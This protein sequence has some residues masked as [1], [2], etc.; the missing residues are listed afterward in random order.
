MHRKGR[1][2]HLTIPSTGFKTHSA[3]HRAGSLF[4]VA[5]VTLA[6]FPGPF[7]ALDTGVDGSYRYGLNRL[8]AEGA[9]HG[10]D[11]VFNYGPLGYL[12][13][14]LD[15]GTNLMEAL[16]FQL[17][18]LALFAWALFLMARQQDG[19]WMLAGFA[20]AYLL[21]L[22]MGF[23]FDYQLLLLIAMLLILLHRHPRN[24]ALAAAA[25]ALAGLTVFMKFS[26]GIAAMGMLLASIALLVAGPR[27]R[28]KR[29]VAAG[30]GTAGAVLLAVGWM[31]FGEL[32]HLGRWIRLSLEIVR[33]YSGAM[34]LSGSPTAL[35]LAQAILLV[36]V[37]LLAWAARGRSELLPVLLVLLVPL[38]LAYKHGFVRQATHAALFFR[39]ALPMVALLPVFAGTGRNRRAALAGL[40]AV[41]LLVLGAIPVSRGMVPPGFAWRASGLAGAQNLLNLARQGSI[42]KELAAR[43]GANLAKNRL[44]DSWLEQINER[45][46]TV[47]VVPYDLSYL[48]ANGL[49][50][51]PN[52]VLQTYT[53]YTEVL[54]RESSRHF[55]GPS[56]PDT[57][58]FHPAT[59]DLRHAL[60]DAP[61]TAREILRHYGLEA[62]E[63]HPPRLLLMD[64]HRSIGPPPAEMASLQA[65][66]G[67]W[68]EV[69]ESDDLLFAAL[70]LRLTLRGRIQGISLRLPA[71]A[72]EFAYADGHTVT[73]RILADTA[74]SGLLINFLPRTTA[75]TARLFAG[76]PDEKVV[77]FRLGGSGALLYESPFRLRWLAEP[78]P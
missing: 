41:A 57:L 3:A 49:S 44:P 7:Q 65:S 10:R 59:I 36:M 18:V 40:G 37:G 72:A 17:A 6:A 28:N 16:V 69:P 75:G 9:V 27:G 73:V 71:V 46:G 56:R 43:S 35:L 12:L 42:E 25:G 21:A 4:L 11:I 38:V 48:A 20:S 1:L 45:G 13:F 47:D 67:E 78:L 30:L 55:A 29:A 53:A 68:I 51:S 31:H 32:S 52:P 8:A 76:T 66:I 70:D 26:L 50:W 19:P 34:S 62:S 64:R 33:G 58:I 63:N 61:L 23:S 24:M 15:F 74:V 77:R 2:K 54:D 22:G 14:P 5:F 39:F 60:L